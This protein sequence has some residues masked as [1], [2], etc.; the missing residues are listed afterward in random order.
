[1]TVLLTAPEPTRT[2]RAIQATREIPWIALT[3]LTVAI[4]I[5]ESNPLLAAHSLWAPVSVLLLIPCYRAVPATRLRSFWLWVLAAAAVGTL[6]SATLAG[7]PLSEAVGPVMAIGSVTGTLYF[8]RAM[9]ARGRRYL[10]TATS[11]LG[12]GML[13]HAFVLIPL[14]ADVAGNPWK[15]GIGYATSI[16][17]LSVCA[18]V[19]RTWLVVTAA[20]VLAAVSFAEATRALGV[21]LALA[22]A[23]VLLSRVGRDQ[24]TFTRVGG[25]LCVGALLGMTAL[26][27]ADALLNSELFASSAE[28]FAEQAEVNDNS[29]LAGR[30][31]PPISIAAISES[32]FVGQGP[33]PVPTPAIVDRAIV[34]AQDLGYRQ[35]DQLVKWWTQDGTIYMHSVLADSWVRSG[36]LAAA[37]YLL[38]LGYFLVTFVRA[39]V[40]AVA[41][42]ALALFL[43][44]QS[45]WDVLF[46]PPAYGQLVLIGLAIGLAGVTVVGPRS[47]TP[48]KT[49]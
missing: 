29:L 1:M 24:P 13:Y 34:V 19:G 33:R 10:W 35:I 46:S 45:T 14:S 36:I 23:V 26:Y 6:G 41:Y 4:P 49:R 32:P 38:A 21:V 16:I 40:G 8:V 42:S 2:Q 25:R 39:I 18:A 31:E 37:T 47:S 22:A 44:A 7:A 15:F 3:P 43:V 17:V 9:A 30:T 28:R 48:A 12:L 11:C 27:G 5:L 20:L